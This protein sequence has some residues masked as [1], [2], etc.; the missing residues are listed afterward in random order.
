[1]RQLSAA[2]INKLNTKLVDKAA[3]LIEKNCPEAHPEIKDA[4]LQYSLNYANAY[5][6]SEGQLPDANTLTQLGS[7]SLEE[8]QEYEGILPENIQTGFMQQQAERPAPDHAH[9]R[10]VFGEHERLYFTLPDEKNPEQD[11]LQALVEAALPDYEIDF[12]KG[13]ASNDGGKNNMRLGRLLNKN[14]EE[15]LFKQWDKRCS[16]KT[17]KLMMVVSRRPEDIARAST[18]RHWTSCM[19]EYGDFPER[20]EDDI[21]QG[22]IVAYLVSESDPEIMRPLSR[23]LIKPYHGGKDGTQTAMY[24]DNAYG[25]EHEAF[26]AA[27]HKLCRDYF[28]NGLQGNFQLDEHLYQDGITGFTIENGEVHLPKAQQKKANVRHLPDNLRNGQCS[29]E[30]LLKHLGYKYQNQDGKLVLERGQLNL[31]GMGIRQLP[32]LSMVECGHL[33]CD[34]N[35]LTELPALPQSLTSLSAR[36]NKIET[37]PEKLPPNLGSLDVSQNQL[38]WLPSQLPQNLDELD[39]SENQMLELPELPENLRILNCSGNQIVSLPQLP[40]NLD[41]LS[42]ALNNLSTLP[43]E[44]PQNLRHLNCSHNRMIV[45]PMSLPDSLLDINCAHNN[46]GDLPRTLPPQL[47]HL[48]CAHNRLSEL[49]HLPE[50]LEKLSCDGNDLSHLQHDMPQGLHLLTCKK[51]PRLED[52]PASVPS[53]CTLKWEG[54]RREND[55]PA[56]ETLEMA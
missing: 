35:E 25:I 31:S 11:R 15:G 51:N 52:L 39:C 54:R 33:N 13:T 9:L 20:I 7:L 8:L 5:E 24:P 30:D 41:N 14:G 27:A 2:H 46:L 23:H 44:L 49:P 29:A 55:Y 36:A 48:D 6:A 37:L 4:L 12:E 17:E 38:M 53:T 42:C 32:D 47:K 40:E 43:G 3:R 34:Q 16:Q 22:S 21:S 56:K 19:N 26:D 10:P 45:M 50:T 18:G 1:M 28:N